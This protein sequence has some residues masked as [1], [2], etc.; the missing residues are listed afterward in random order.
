MKL[1]HLSDLHL[2]KRV[3]GFSML[4]DQKYVLEKIL[5]LADKEKPD[6][7]LLVGDIYDKSV[8]PIEAVQ[9][10]DE[11]LTA[12]RKRGIAVFLISGNHDSAQRLHFGS[13]LL[14]EE[15]I[16][17]AGEFTG[18]PYHIKKEDHYGEIHF[19]LLPFL[20]P[21]MTMPFREEEASQSYEEAVKWA[22]EQV[23][24]DFSKRNVLLAHQ[25]VTWRGKA[26]ESDSETK[27]LGGV[28]AVD[29]SLFFHFD[30]T[31]LG[32]LHQPQKI[33][34]EF[35]RYSGSPLPYSFSEIRRKK[36]VTVVELREKG[37][38]SLSFLPLPSLH[39]MRE[40]K[41][42]F[43]SILQV[44]KE[45]GGS[46]DYVR[47]ILTDQ[48]ALH[49]PVGQL[50]TYYPNLM[51]LEMEKRERRQNSKTLSLQEERSPLELFQLFYEER[52]GKSLSD[53]QKKTVKT[54]WQEMGE[55]ES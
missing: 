39:G 55:G 34:K 54:L 48:D 37:D 7:V 25:F 22:L 30:Y 20:K 11:F 15:A 26:E 14:E 36:G 28:D 51:T 19:Y 4:Q 43:T 23:E 52:Q 27:I 13:R 49:D 41:G 3:Y 50:R 32:H 45:E 38:V 5:E 21:A 16:Y 17:V 31:A 6:G 18:K 42:E 24:I 9:L 53:A 8:P 47:V 44:A 12:W 46:T 2:G 40:I 33:G 35:I 10:L 29:A 1:F